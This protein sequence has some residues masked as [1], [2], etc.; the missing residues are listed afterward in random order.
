MSL[1]EAGWSV[2]T[3]PLGDYAGAEFSYM[4]E[5]NIEIEESANEVAVEKTLNGIRNSALRV[6]EDFYDDC[7]NNSLSMRSCQ[8][9]YRFGAFH[10]LSRS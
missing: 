3:V 1:P 4:G 10:V 6:F 2:P 5:E 7:I 9:T 8:S